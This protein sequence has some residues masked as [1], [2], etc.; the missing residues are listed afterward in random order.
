[1]LVGTPMVQP[2]GDDALPLQPRK[3]KLWLK[4]LP[5]ADMGETTRRLLQAVRSLNNRSLPAADR[6]EI[7]ELMRPS[8]HMAQEHLGRHFI[9]RSLP[10]PPRGLQIAH[11]AGELLAETSTGYLKVLRDVRGT[12]RT[13][14][15]SRQLTTAVYRGL[16]LLGTQQRHAARLYLPPPA[17]NLASHARTPE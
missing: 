16:C 15:S 4:T 17:G 7:M 11:V 6:L 1:M 2:P 12:K 14:L 9:N 13:G 3:V 5:L 10:L 8:L